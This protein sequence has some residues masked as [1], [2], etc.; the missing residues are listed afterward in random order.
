MPRESKEELEGAQQRP[1]E[2]QST[3][4]LSRDETWLMGVGTGVGVQRVEE[5]S[6]KGSVSC[7]K[8]LR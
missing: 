4:I 5:P 1:L 8:V 2:G 7:V 3:C 6:R